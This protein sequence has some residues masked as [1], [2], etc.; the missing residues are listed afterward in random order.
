MQRNMYKNVPNSFTHNS[1]KWNY[2]YY[3]NRKTGNL[4]ISVSV[5]LTLVS[6]LL[7][8]IR[9]CV[10]YNAVYK[11]FRNGQMV[12]KV[13]VMLPHIL[14]SLLGIVSEPSRGAKMVY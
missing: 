7:C 13:R 9:E 3:T 10:L 6:I 12:R 4:L 1:Q 14:V 5:G 2:E 11:K 8:Q